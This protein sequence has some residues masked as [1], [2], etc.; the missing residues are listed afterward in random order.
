M[1]I[2]NK[3]KGIVKSIGLHIILGKLKFS[4]SKG[5]L[6]Q[7]LHFVT[8]GHLFRKYRIKKYLFVKRN[9]LKKLQIGGGYHTKHNWING[10]LIAGEIYLNVVRKFPFP[11]GSID[12]IFAEQFIEHLDFDDG[13]RCLNECHRVLKEGGKIRLS[14]P[15]IESLISTYKDQNP[16]VR[17]KTAMERHRKNHNRGL[18]SPCHFL[19]DFFRLWGHSFIYDKHTLILQLKNAG[20]SNITRQ[21]FGYSKDEYL[22]D[23]ERHADV[24]WMKDGWALILEGEK[25]S[26]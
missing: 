16:K 12:I 17:L 24:E 10:D 2:R 6:R 20:F 13:F 8:K 4:F 25:V 18:S 22:S 11:D 1:I 15:D 21:E 23:L 19:N 26:E 14:T 9:T 3:A 5:K 7:I